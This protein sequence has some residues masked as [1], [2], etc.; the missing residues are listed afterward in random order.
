MKIT[1]QLSFIS[2]IFIL[3][4]TSIESL[5]RTESL[6]SPI[7]NFRFRSQ[8]FPASTSLGPSSNPTESVEIRARLGF[9]LE[10][11]LKFLLHSEEQYVRKSNL[12]DSPKESIAYPIQNY[13]SWNPNGFFDIK[14]GRQQLAFGSERIIGTADWNYKSRIFDGT[15]INLTSFT[16]SLAIF[17]MSIDKDSGGSVPFGGNHQF[18]G[19]YLSLKTFGLDEIDF[20]YLINKN[21]NLIQPINLKTLGARIRHRSES[22]IFE[23]EYTKQTGDIRNLVINDEQKDLMIG[24]LF[25]F[26]PSKFISIGALSATHNYFQLF[27][28]GHRFLGFMDY[29]SRRSI[30]DL[31]LTSSYA[32][33]RTLKSGIEYHDFYRINA[34]TSPYAFNGTSAI[35]AGNVNANSKSIGKELDLFI[36]KKHSSLISKLKLITSYTT[37]VAFFNPGPYLDKNLA[38]PKDLLITFWLGVQTLF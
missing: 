25:N 29:F 24:Y 11:P 15:R 31:Y 19:A 30:Q 26:D 13:I 3:I 33:S 37:G 6:F 17:Q 7:G 8:S 1:S 27:P 34:S 28:S 12:K 5:G 10:I 21:L 36:E 35:N 38:Q 14:Y 2:L 23:A 32:W 16:H 22:F 9:E 20:Y 18:T 4:N